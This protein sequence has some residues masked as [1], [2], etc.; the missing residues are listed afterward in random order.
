[1]DKNRRFVKQSDVERVGLKG[2][3]KSIITYK[4]SFVDS[5]ERCT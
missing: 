1:M 2:K 3:V 5:L 4:Y